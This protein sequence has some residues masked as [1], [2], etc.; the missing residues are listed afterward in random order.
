[1]TAPARG[2]V[3]QSG[4]TA[5]PVTRDPEPNRSG[6]DVKTFSDLTLRHGIERH[7]DDAATQDE[8]LRRSAGP[9]P[10][11]EQ[12]PGGGI[13]H[14]WRNAQQADRQFRHTVTTGHGGASLS[15]L[16]MRVLSPPQTLSM[17]RRAGSNG[18]SQRK[19]GSVGI[20]VGFGPGSRAPRTQQP[21]HEAG[22]RD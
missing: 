18:P 6:S 3:D 9:D 1:M 17:S 5:P 20:G 7:E 4:G 13:T 14:P 8:S 19:I 2:V 22:E 15:Q 10:A 21:F 12:T 16:S 11:L